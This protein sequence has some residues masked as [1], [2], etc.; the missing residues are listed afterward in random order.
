MVPHL[1][2]GCCPRLL[3]ETA[4]FGAKRIPGLWSA[5][6][7]NSVRGVIFVEEIMKQRLRHRVRVIA[8]LF[9][10]AVAIAR[11]RSQR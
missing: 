5:L 8:I 3:H 11:L 4:P 6:I 10:F 7:G 1:V 9:A 2:A